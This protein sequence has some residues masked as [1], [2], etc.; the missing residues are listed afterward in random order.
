MLKSAKVLTLMALLV[1]VAVFVSVALQHWTS[2][3]LVL[4]SQS[5]PRGSI[6]LLEAGAKSDRLTIRVKQPSGAYGYSTAWVLRHRASDGG[7]LD[8]WW[9]VGSLDGSRGRVVDF[10]DKGFATPAYSFNGDRTLTLPLPRGLPS[11]PYQLASTPRGPR[12]LT[13]SVVLACSSA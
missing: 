9:L 1:G 2:Q 4:S 10:A 12:A 7:W 3:C 13:M 11:G 6:A 5:A 8:V